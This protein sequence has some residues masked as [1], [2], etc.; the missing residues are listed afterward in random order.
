LVLVLVGQIK[1]VIGMVCTE[2]VLE[3]EAVLE[4][5]GLKETVEVTVHFKQT[6]DHSRGQTPKT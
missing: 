1:E 3:E 2:K 4:G 6:A 5:C